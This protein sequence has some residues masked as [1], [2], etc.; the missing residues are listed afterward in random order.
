MNRPK[1]GQHFLRD[2]NIVRKI[3][4]LASLNPTDTVL[5]IGTGHGVLTKALAKTAKEIITI[6]FDRGLYAKLK[7]TLGSLPNVTLVCSDGLTYPIDTLPHP[8]KVV[9]NLPYYISTP[10]I[11]RFFE[12]HVRISEMILMLQQ[13]VANRLVAIPGTKNYSPLSI[14]SQYY[15]QPRLAFKVSRNCFHPSPKVDSAVVQLKI[16]KTPPVQVLN[17]ASFFKVVRGGFAH[18]RKVLRNSLRDSGFSKQVLDRAHSASSLDLN[19]RAET[20][21]L[22]EFASLSDILFELTSRNMIA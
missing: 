18:R 16:R 2:L 14:A 19:R 10:L 9:A 3:V 7:N 17:E 20:L 6:E 22:K 15:T 8:F 1:L 5:E 12:E 11:F 4:Q 21:S 13:E